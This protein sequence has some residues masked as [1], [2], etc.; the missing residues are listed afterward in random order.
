MHRP[1]KHLRNL[2]LHILCVMQLTTIPV[3]SQLNLPVFDL[4]YQLSNQ[5][6]ESIHDTTTFS[7][8]YDFIVIGSGSGGSVVANRLSENPN[9]NVLLLEAGVEENFVSDVPLTP[10]VTILT[11]TY[12]LTLNYTY[13]QY[14]WPK[15]PINFNVLINNIWFYYF[16]FD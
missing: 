9:W 7:H 16:R 2:L 11:S 14:E 10:S 13:Q 8:A 12:E 4:I 6:N 3:S 1:I 5:F 15:I